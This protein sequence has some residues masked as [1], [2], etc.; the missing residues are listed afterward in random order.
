MVASGLAM[1]LACV[2]KQVQELCGAALCQVDGTGKA[3]L[4]RG[5]P[6]VVLRCLVRAAV[7]L[8]GCSA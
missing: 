4:L 8:S 1:A 7:R 3:K 5:F 2:V 6:G